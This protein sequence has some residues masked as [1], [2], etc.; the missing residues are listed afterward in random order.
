MRR[1]AGCSSARGPPAALRFAAA[2]SPDRPGPI[3]HVA[4]EQNTGSGIDGIVLF[5]PARS[6][7]D[8]DVTNRPGVDSV[9]EPAAVRSDLDDVPGLRQA[10]GL[11]D[12]ARISAL[13]GDP[14]P[15]FLG[16]RAGENGS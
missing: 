5:Q 14:L 16:G 2:R 9:D 13:R 1:E 12:N 11:V 6:H 8:G 10:G 3:A 15:G 7:F 4:I